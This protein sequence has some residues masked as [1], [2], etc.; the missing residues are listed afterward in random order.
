M[1]TPKQRCRRCG[2][3]PSNPLARNCTECGLSLVARFERAP[4][5]AAE[6]SGL[7]KG[8]QSVSNAGLHDAGVEQPRE[9][10]RRAT[11]EPPPI[12]EPGAGVSEV[13]D[14]PSIGLATPQE[15]MT[16]RSRLNDLLA[17]TTALSVLLITAVVAVSFILRVRT[18]K[19]ALPI[20]AGDDYA[21]PFVLNRPPPI[22]LLAHPTPAPSA[23]PILKMVP[24]RTPMPK[25]KAERQARHVRLTRA[26]LYLPPLR[27]GMPDTSA[28]SEDWTTHGSFRSKANCEKFRRDAIGDTVTAREADPDREIYDVRIRLLMAGR[29]EDERQEQ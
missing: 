13:R 22:R 9:H 29:C 18:P 10:S 1:V 11:P 6:K 3:I 4:L 21:D 8:S 25:R 12:P 14:D 28:P 27:H 23:M 17:V 19:P 16:P 24:T 7:V 5:P 2:A 20:S 15:R 26:N